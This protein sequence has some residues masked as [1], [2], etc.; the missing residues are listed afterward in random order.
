MN[1]ALEMAKQECENCEVKLQDL[2]AKNDDIQNENW[3]NKLKALE[4]EFQIKEKARQDTQAKADQAMAQMGAKLNVFKDPFFDRASETE[5]IMSKIRALRGD[6]P[7]D[8]SDSSVP[9]TSDG[10]ASGRSPGFRGSN[11][12]P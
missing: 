7:F 10:G 12:S 1:V 5:D 3:E 4:H 6:N 2:Q 9:S 11:L 8:P